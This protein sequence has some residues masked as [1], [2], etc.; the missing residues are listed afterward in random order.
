[1]NAKEA[2][3]LALSSFDKEYNEVKIKIQN[4]AK[5]GNFSYN[6]CDLLNSETVKRLEKEG[7]KVSQ[8]IDPR[9]E[10]YC[11]ISW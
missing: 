9:N 3:E 2:R 11:H 1:M 7:Y 5:I 4:Q 6:N 8:G 10:S